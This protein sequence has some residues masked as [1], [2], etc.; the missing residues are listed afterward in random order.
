[1]ELLEGRRENKPLCLQEGEE[2][3]R[4]QEKNGKAVF[5]YDWE[6]QVD[7]AGCEVEKRAFWVEE[8]FVY[9]Y[10]VMTKFGMFRELTI[11]FAEKLQEK[12]KKKNGREKMMR[13]EARK[14]SSKQVVK[15]THSKDFETDS[16]IIS[17]E[18]YFKTRRED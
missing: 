10:G 7:K 8:K 5:K 12:L 18:I 3:V 15:I 14:L 2:N 11:F 13:Y 1:M 6:N 16:L 17:E 9:V 4:S